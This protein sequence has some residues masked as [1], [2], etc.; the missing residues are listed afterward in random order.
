MD[1][2]WNAMGAK[3]SVAVL[4]AKHK[5][6]SREERKVLCE[7]SWLESDGVDT[8]VPEFTVSAAVHRQGSQ[9]MPQMCSSNQTIQGPALNSAAKKDTPDDEQQPGCNREDIAYHGT[10]AEPLLPETLLHLQ[11]K[12]S[13][14]TEDTKMSDGHGHHSSFT[15]EDQRCFPGGGPKPFK[16]VVPSMPESGTHGITEEASFVPA[17]CNNGQDALSHQESEGHS[18]S[19][20]WKES[21]ITI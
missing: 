6:I 5:I 3:R 12:L 20:D 11:D 7:D 16:E 8:P 18:S 4:K 10:L 2:V 15:V 9:A 21:I 19:M 17:G 1:F 13:R 14:H